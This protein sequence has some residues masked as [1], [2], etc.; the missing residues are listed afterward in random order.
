MRF[1]IKN[2][3]TNQ[4]ETFENIL[5]NDLISKICSDVQIKFNFEHGAKLVWMGKILNENLS[6]KD[7]FSSNEIKTYNIICIPKSLPPNNTTDLFSERQV[8]ATIIMI[9]YLLQRNIQMYQMFHNFNPN[10]YQNP[11]MKFILNNNFNKTLREILGQ[12]AQIANQ[13][14]NSE[15]IQLNISQI[16]YPPVT[17][18]VTVEVVSAEDDENYEDMPSLIPMIYSETVIIDPPQINQ[19]NMQVLIENLLTNF[20]L[21]QS[22]LSEDD[23]V[24]ITTLMSLGFEREQIIQIYLFTNK[25]VNITADILLR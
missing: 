13:I 14:D 8:R 5:E 18:P 19:N 12:S 23:E 1:I 4:T 20:N 10:I 25:N 24:N 16:T 7:Y 11:I 22:Q 21:N 3:A 2:I 15:Q 9:I 17:E 6:V